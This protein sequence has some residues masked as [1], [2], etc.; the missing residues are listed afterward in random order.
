[1]FCQSEIENFQASL[2]SDEEVAGL[3]VTVDHSLSMSRGHRFGELRAQSSRLRFIERPVS[4]FFAQ[5]NTVNQFHNEK[6][7]VPFAAKIMDSFD[8]W[9]IQLCQC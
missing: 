3:Q 1:V 5:R 4:K 2:D 9:V 7:N 6:I 8:V